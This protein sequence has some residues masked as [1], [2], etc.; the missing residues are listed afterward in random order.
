[1]E[2][3]ELRPRVLALATGV[4]LAL[5]AAPAVAASGPAPSRMVL[6]ASDLPPGF[7]V[8]RSETG[9][10][11]NSDVVRDF[12][13]AIQP[14]LRRWG[15]VT[16]YEALYKQRDIKRGALPGVIEFGAS[17]VLYA[18]PAARTRRWPTDPPAAGTKR[19]RSSGSADTGPSA[20]TLAS[21]LA[22]GG[23]A[24]PEFGSSSFSGGIAGRRAASTLQRSRAP[25]R[26]WPR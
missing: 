19:L 12:G 8:V 14:K 7:L 21:V 18:P 23:S 16:G 6:R 24:P 1:V 3:A 26:R 10:Y 9:P 13:P 25:S 11:T 20:P 15:R 17:A 2:S 4:V 5:L 22:A